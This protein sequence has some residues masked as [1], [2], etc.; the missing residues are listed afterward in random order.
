[1]TDTKDPLRFVLV[2]DDP[3][4]LFFI[5]RTF[6]QV[7]ITA[8]IERLNN[9]EEFIR[10]LEDQTKTPGRKLDCALMDLNMP[11]K[12]GWETLKEMQSKGLGAGVPVV[13]LSHSKQS[14]VDELLSLGA[15]A[16]MEKP[17][18][19]EEYKS[20]VRAL[21]SYATGSSVKPQN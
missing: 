4:M 17:V 13:I 5:Q 14:N 3:H 21:V 12:N 2:D 8:E 15:A 1:M 16:F 18:D 7:G 20:F 11:R 19:L 9:G 10:F 6:R